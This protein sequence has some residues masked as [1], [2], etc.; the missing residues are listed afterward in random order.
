MPE[1]KDTNGERLSFIQ[2]IGR[3]FT[4]PI[5]S[6]DASGEKEMKT[7]IFRRV[8]ALGHTLRESFA[9]TV[10]APVN[11]GSRAVELTAGAVVDVPASGSMA[12]GNVI[13]AIGY[14]FQWIG[15]KLSRASEALISR[16]IGALRTGYSNAVR[17]ILFLP[18]RQEGSAEWPTA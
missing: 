15:S 3:F 18:K 10:E 9:N 8:G 7:N 13:Q 6:P 11:I 2:R 12:A 14:P 4:R 16:T 17:T 1:Q 5:E